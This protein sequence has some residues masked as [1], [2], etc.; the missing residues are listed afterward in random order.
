MELVELICSWGAS[1]SRSHL[2]G[3][4]C[5]HSLYDLTVRARLMKETHV[6]VILSSIEM[7]MFCWKNRG[8]ERGRIR[9]IIYTTASY[10]FHSSFP[11]SL[12]GWWQCLSR[13]SLLHS[14]HAF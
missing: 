12:Y 14:D 13:G 4:K 3:A 7:C 2:A 11:Q 6:E 10:I 9:E 8:M 1:D 5:I